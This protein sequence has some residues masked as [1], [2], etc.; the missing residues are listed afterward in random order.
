MSRFCPKRDGFCEL[1][2]ALNG[3]GSEIKRFVHKI[4]EC[5]NTTTAQTQ[6]GNETSGELQELALGAEQPRGVA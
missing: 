3:A 6:T 2:P 5:W 4:E 1:T